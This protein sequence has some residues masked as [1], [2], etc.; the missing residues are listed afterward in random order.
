MTLLRQLLVERP[1]LRVAGVDPSPVMLK[2]YT[3]KP[4]AWEMRI[5][6]TTCIPFPRASF[7]V[8]TSVFA[9]HETVVR[10]RVQ[11]LRE[12]ARVLRWMEY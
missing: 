3:G 7:D 11:A 6:S 10:E 4:P 12:I 9:W 2:P 8:P 1:G 5:G